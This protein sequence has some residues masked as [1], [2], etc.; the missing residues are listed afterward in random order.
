MKVIFTSVTYDVLEFESAKEGTTQKEFW[1]IFKKKHM[2]YDLKD[3]MKEAVE[4]AIDF[5]D[6]KNVG[7]IN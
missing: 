2:T 1:N 7:I 3:N 5:T 4:I 6:Q